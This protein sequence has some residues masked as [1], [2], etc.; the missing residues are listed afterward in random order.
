[1][2]R[3]KVTKGMSMTPNLYKVLKQCVFQGSTVD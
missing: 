2:G 3:A 1:M